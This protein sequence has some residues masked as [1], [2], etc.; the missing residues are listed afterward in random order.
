MSWVSDL[1]LGLSASQVGFGLSGRRTRQR[2]GVASWKK[3]PSLDRSCASERLEELE[4]FKTEDRRLETVRLDGARGKREREKE[5]GS[6]LGTAFSA[7]SAPSGAKAGYLDQIIA[8]ANFQFWQFGTASH[9]SSLFTLG[10]LRAGQINSPAFTSELPPVM[11]ST[12]APA[13][14]AQAAGVAPKGMR[15]NGLSPSFPTAVGLDLPT[16]P[17]R[18][19]LA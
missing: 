4:A 14:T 5:R 12:E 3:A 8:R 13:T 7:R 18:Q 10:C 17:I 11:S 15:K 2:G 16:D 1:F 19:K 9:S 6:G